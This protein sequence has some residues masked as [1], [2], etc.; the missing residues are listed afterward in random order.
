MLGYTHL[1]GGRRGKDFVLAP[2]SQL[3]DIEGKW[4]SLLYL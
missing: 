3:C 2:Y 4:L 1:E